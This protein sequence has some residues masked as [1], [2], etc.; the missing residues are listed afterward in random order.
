MLLGLLPLVVICIGL[1]VGVVVREQQIAGKVGAATKTTTGLVRSVESNV[2]TVDWTDH[3]GRR[4]A[5]RFAFPASSA[6]RPGAQVTVHY[7]PD[8]SR[9]YASGDTTYSRIDDLVGGVL[10]IVVVL[11]AA[12]VATWVRIWRRRAAERRPATRAR[13]TR[14]R[15]RFALFHRS[16]LVLAE[17][18]RE[19]WVPVFWDPVLTNL[20]ANTPCGVHGDPARDGLVVIDVGDARIWPSGR[21]RTRLP[22]GEQIANAGTW[23]KGAAIEPG[24]PVSLPRQALGDAVFVTLAPVL[25]VLWA[26]VEGLG[27]A[28][29]GLATALLAG[30]LF[31]LPSAYGADP[32]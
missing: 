3:S 19:W 7:T 21:V 9:A 2:A 23:K 17:A 26:Y 30:V 29:F 32:T 24:T 18:R 5:S 13:A 11:A 6:P 4:H 10:Y 8:A 28:G 14:V 22:R 15:V 27:G 1:L 31:W 16:F 12:T 20:P 25:G